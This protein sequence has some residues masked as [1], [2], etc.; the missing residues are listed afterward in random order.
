MR[1]RFGALLRVASLPPASEKVLRI[2]DGLLVSMMATDLPPMN[3][4]IV[5]R[6]KKIPTSSVRHGPEILI[7]ESRILTISIDMEAG[8]RRFLDAP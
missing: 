3:S 7:R 6:A 5:G 1:A 4:C 2:E 8:A